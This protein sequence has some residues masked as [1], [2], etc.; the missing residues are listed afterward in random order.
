MATKTIISKGQIWSILRRT[1][2]LF[3]INLPG[4]LE[5]LKCLA[6][7]LDSFWPLIHN[8]ATPLVRLMEKTGGKS[9]F[10]GLKVNKQKLS[11]AFYFGRSIPG[12]KEAKNNSVCMKAQREKEKDYLA[13]TKKA[14]ELVPRWENFW[15]KMEAGQ[16]REWA[17]KLLLP[18]PAGMSVWMLRNVRKRH[19]YYGARDGSSVKL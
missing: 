15:T 6:W 17:S 10:K 14:L 18:R 1:D 11:S 7:K 12:D 4:C 8:H 13:D 19:C 2:V 5:N 16:K 3:N 9:L